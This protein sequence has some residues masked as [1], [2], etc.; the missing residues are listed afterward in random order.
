MLSF[1]S[2]L[3]RSILDRAAIVNEQKMTP[4]IIQIKLNIFCNNVYGIKS[5]NPTVHIVFIDQQKDMT[6]N[7]QVDRF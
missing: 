4:K 5:P 6:Y 7:S 1:S 3:D 2:Y